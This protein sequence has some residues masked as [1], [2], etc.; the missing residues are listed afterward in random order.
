MRR[1]EMLLSIL[2][3]RDAVD[4]FES[5]GKMKLICI[6]NHGTDFA[7][8]LLCFFEKL[9]CFSHAIDHQEALG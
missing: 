5:A 4:I 9:L 3:G 2:P 1:I 6:A 8:G 7:D